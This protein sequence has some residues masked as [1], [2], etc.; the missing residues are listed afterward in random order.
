MFPFTLSESIYWAPPVYPG[1]KSS[2]LSTHSFCFSSAQEAPTA[3][4]LDF[5]FLFPEAPQSLTGMVFH[6][7]P[8]PLP[9]HLVP[10]CHGL[11][12]KVNPAHS[13]P[14]SKPC[15]SSTS[16]APTLSRCGFELSELRPKH[17][18][19]SGG[20]PGFC[21]VKL[22]LLLPVLQISPPLPGSDQTSPSPAGVGAPQAGEDPSFST[23]LS[24]WESLDHSFLPQS[25]IPA[26]APFTLTPPSP[27]QCPARSLAH[28]RLPVDGERDL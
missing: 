3:T 7:Q 11:L 20:S 19:Y 15:M 27:T 10:H 26:I 22:F 16:K 25:P 28:G 8:H 21:T 12:G 14:C 17:L 2:C 23:D 5:S 13:F 6:L 1:S 24:A 4:C 9:S 18:D